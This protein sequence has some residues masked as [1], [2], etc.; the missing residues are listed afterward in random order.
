MEMKTV[1]KYLDVTK[2]L[3]QG[4]AIFRHYTNHDL[5]T[6]FRTFNQHSISIEKIPASMA[7]T[8]SATLMTSG[9]SLIRS[10]Q[11]NERDNEIQNNKQ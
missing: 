10:F 5:R 3:G 6:I 1:I 4:K 2:Y 9:I 8:Q 7:D 11:S